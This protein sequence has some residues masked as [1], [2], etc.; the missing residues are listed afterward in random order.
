[1]KNPVFAGAAA[2]AL[3]ISI[4]AGAALAQQSP[5]RD[6]DGNIV[7]EPIVVQGTGTANG[8]GGGEG[9]EQKPALATEQE[10]VLTTRV[11]KEEM[12][13]RQVTDIR[14]IDRLAPGVSY[15]EASRSF[16]VRGLDRTRVLTTIDGIRV[17]WFEDG[18]RGV[19]GGVNTFEFDSLSAV[20]II[21]GSDSSIFGSGGIG[22]VVAFRTLDPEDLIKDGRNWGSIT[23]SGFDSKDDSWRVDEAA[24]ARV[25]NTFVLVQGGYRNGHELENKGDIDAYGTSRT[26]KNPSDYDQENLLVKLH[27]YVDGGH[28]F[29]FTGELFNRDEDIDDRLATT[30]LTYALGSVTT[31]D[32]TKRQRVSAD[33]RYDGGGAIDQAEAVIYWQR[34]QLESD[35]RSIRITPG[36]PN[37]PYRRDNTREQE[38]FGING[39]ALKIF[40]LATTEHRVSFGGELYGSKASSYSA[41]VDNCPPPPYPPFATCSFLHTNQAD[42]PNVDGTTFGAFVQDEIV[43]AGGAIRVTPGL[44]YDWYQEKPQET[45][46]LES[47]PNYDGTLPP[48]S[49]DSNLAGKLRVEYDIDPEITLYAQWAQ[50]FRAPTANELYLDY[51]G[52]G[53]YLRLGNENLKPET[54]N[55]FEIGAK[56]GDQDF[57]GAVSAFY[58]RYKNFIDQSDPVATPTYPL[59]VTDTINRDNVEIYGAEIEGHYRHVSGWHTWG[60]LGAY[61]GRDIDDD[62]HLNTIPTARLMTAVGYETDRW[63]SDVILTIGAG[64]GVDKVE[65][66]TSTTPSYQLV[67]FTVWWKPQVFDGLTLRAGVFNIFD[68]T[69]FKTLDLAATTRNKDYYSEPGRNFKV[70][71]TYQ[72]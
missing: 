63:G 21:K 41:G 31:N 1:M 24:A 55:G 49:S 71:A 30:P 29:G 27:Q 10:T 19:Q 39:S 9:G 32:V 12:E 66:V 22:G 57:G 61:V 17:P 11:T 68:E 4:S 53:T 40:D 14:D 43:L 34:Q 64:R 51:G 50:G 44:R 65:T 62:E 72:F 54:S 37:G 56:A 5:Q 47:N 59:G 18:A 67:D 16:N 6:A 3:L 13:Q 69:Y 48:D 46:G 35:F 36:P 25:D 20:D 45:A 26:E 28:R 70:S 38:I 7:L 8:S 58:N 33:Y 2:S 42:M 15:N 52:P 23:R 60:N